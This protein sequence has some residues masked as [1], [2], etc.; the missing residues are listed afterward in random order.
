MPEQWGVFDKH[1]IPLNDWREHEINPDC[2]CNP[3]YDEEVIVHNSL[4]E[5]ELYER[6]EK[7]LS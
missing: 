7:K 4:D 5:R 3:F 2:W 6:G 1:V